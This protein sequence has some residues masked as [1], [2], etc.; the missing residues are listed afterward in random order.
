MNSAQNAVKEFS[1]ESRKKYSISFALLMIVFLVV[2]QNSVFFVLL[3]KKD[4]LTAKQT[5]LS[6]TNMFLRE[7][8]S[9]HLVWS[10]DL[11]ES[12][13]LNR[14][15]TGELNHNETD[16][17]KWYY[18][19]SG[20][21]EYWELKDEHRAV[22]DKIGPVNVN[23]HNS[24]RMIY[25]EKTGQGKLTVFRNNTKK[26]LVQMDKLI[27]SYIEI[28]SGMIKENMKTLGFYSTLIRIGAL[29]SSLV[30][31]GIILFLS[32]KIIRSIIENNSKFGGAFISLA[33]GDLS[34]R[35]DET[36]G[37]EY[38]VLSKRFNHFSGMIA[39]VISGV[40]SLSADMNQATSHVASVTSDLSENLKD[41]SAFA[42]EINSSMELIK[43]EMHNVSAE[44]FQQSQS[45]T[46]LAD[47]LDEMI[48]GIQN[49]DSQ[50]V[51]AAGLSSELASEAESGRA[52]M[53]DLRGLVTEIAGS[54]GEMSSV[55]E[56]INDISDR[57]NL[58]SLNAAIEAARA[59][60]SGRGFAVV[61]DEISGLAAKT[62]NSIRGIEALIKKNTETSK[63]SELSIIKTADIIESIIVSISDL[64]SF[65]REISLSIS[66]QR[67]LAHT[68]NTAASR[69][70]EGDTA[71]SKSIEEQK[72]G[73]SEITDAT[74][75]INELIQQTVERVDVILEKMLLLDK[76]GKRLNDS[77]EY[78]SA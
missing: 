2:L 12:I 71:I 64:S 10:N 32:R 51:K 40:R 33:E 25:G 18:G 53:N 43:T 77:I 39:N 9:E 46:V 19:F 66:G 4:S 76:K 27:S 42:E 28:N 30:I 65:M 17:A 44:A 29:V 34:V 50:A 58:L 68:L 45:I 7:K 21:A 59:G 31:F 5:A 56:I 15:F 54:S 69:V 48:T 3:L 36:G 6:K 37:D 8:Y 26:Y 61:A 49:I 78:F 13:A 1:I 14:N 47:V 16:F 52:N 73:I 67:E 41:Q 24:A 20:T 22:F 38:R 57:I 60:D 63:R 35:M 62:A 70:R 11:A 23:L 55:T 74:A 72:S 75:R